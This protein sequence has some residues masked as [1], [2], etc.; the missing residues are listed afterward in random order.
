VSAPRTEAEIVAGIYD[1]SYGREVILTRLAQYVQNA[2]MVRDIAKGLLANH[3][4]DF[5]EVLRLR[6]ENDELRAKVERLENA[7]KGKR[8]GPGLLKVS[9]T[10]RGSP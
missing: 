3:E 10:R 7:R 6:H 8:R 9:I 4:R 1:D 5:A 2:E